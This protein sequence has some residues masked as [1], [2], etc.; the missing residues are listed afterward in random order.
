MNKELLLA[1][2]AIQLRMTV[3]LVKA[4]QSA[5]NIYN[6]HL[7]IFTDSFEKFQQSEWLT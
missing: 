1:R 3:L 6:K 5:L 4:S 7:T 2:E